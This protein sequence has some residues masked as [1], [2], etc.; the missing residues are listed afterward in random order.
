[1]RRFR[2]F[3]FGKKYAQSGKKY[4]KNVFRKRMN[5]SSFKYE[6]QEVRTEDGTIARREELSRSNVPDFPFAALERFQRINP[7]VVD[8]FLNEFQKTAESHRKITDREMNRESILK[9]AGLSCGCVIILA[10]LFV[11]ALSLW[12]GHAKTAVLFGSA[13]CVPCLVPL[14]RFAFGRTVPPTAGERKES[15]EAEKASETAEL[16]ESS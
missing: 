11:C 16:E 4:G 5:L 9:F 14:L 8:V 13:V 10:M 7:K 15:Q 12:L 1:M 2:F 6:A 3:G